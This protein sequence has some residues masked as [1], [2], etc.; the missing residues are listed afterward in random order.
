[1]SATLPVEQKSLLDFKKAN[2]AM[3]IRVKHGPMLTA[4]ARRLFNALVKFAQ[5]KE[6][7]V[8]QE[9]SVRDIPVP[10]PTPECPNPE[11][12]FWAAMTD[13]KELA[14]WNSNNAKVFIQLL[15]QLQ[16]TLVE[17]DDNSRFSSVQLIG[18]VQMIKG[19]GRRP[20]VFG[21]EF[22]KAT[23]A[24]LLDPD[25]YT[26][27][28]PDLI[29]GL[30]SSPAIALYE[31]GKRYLT[32]IGGETRKEAWQW[33]YE[34][35]TGNP[36]GSGAKQVD[37][38]GVNAYR[39]F[40]RDALL[41]AVEEINRVTDIRLELIEFKKGR[42]VEQLQFIVSQAHAPA[43]PLSPKNELLI[44][45]LTQLGMSVEQATLLATEFS[46]DVIHRN[47][48]LCRDR[49]GNT[50][51]EPLRSVYAYVRSALNDD[52]AANTAKA[53]LTVTDVEAKPVRA[54]KARTKEE[55]KVK[56]KEPSSAATPSSSEQ[57]DFF[58]AFN[59]LN[60][61]DRDVVLSMLLEERP[62]MATIKPGGAAFKGM[63]TGWIKQK[64]P[65]WRRTYLH[66]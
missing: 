39:Y 13:L 56:T 18:S 61:D 64:T 52:Y 60:E 63:V 36:V 40:K 31:I 42:K 58:K 7:G 26:L 49:I 35:M 48:K 37:K 12:Y 17:A 11:D 2:D 14:G 38:H 22:P 25:S 45:A 57:D 10:K 51:L 41:P 3:V 16:T 53:N 34:T 28:S 50:S 1:M 43:I 5:Q 30:T 65:E 8:V 19:V 46:S 23:K 20:S 27:L 55:A 15:Q 24:A 54:S 33:W 4:N 62:L 9:T 47:L 44:A 6:F 21:W 32:N 29:N 59:Q 66:Q